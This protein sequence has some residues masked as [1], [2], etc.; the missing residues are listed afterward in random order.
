MPAFTCCDRCRNVAGVS[1]ALLEVQL[2]AG[3]KRAQYCSP[4]CQ[5][6]AWRHGHKAACKAEAARLAAA[7]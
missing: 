2:C 7:D 5:K 4:V 1:E 6:A 3:C